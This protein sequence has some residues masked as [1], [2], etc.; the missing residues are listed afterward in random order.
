MQDR[1]AQADILR[2]KKII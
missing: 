2:G 1:D